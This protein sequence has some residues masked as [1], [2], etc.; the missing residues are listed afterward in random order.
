MRPISVLALLG[1]LLLVS[2]CTPEVPLVT[3]PPSPSAEPA[4]ATEE[5]ALAAAEEAYAA[6]LAVSD[7]ILMDGG[8]DPERLLE[9]AT[10]EVFEIELEGYEFMAS[11]GLVSTGGSRIHSVQLQQY[12]PSTPERLVAAYFCV[13]L[14]EVDVLDATGTSV[15]AESRRDKNQFEVVFALRVSRLVVAEKAMWDGDG[16]C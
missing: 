15:V 10:R 6:Y 13:D 5:E 8:A 14:S 16:V 11:E 2:G 4:F 12:S 7:Q 1:G 3:P 9:V